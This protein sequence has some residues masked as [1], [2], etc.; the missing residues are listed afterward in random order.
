[1]APLNPTG[2]CACGC[3]ERTKLAVQDRPS[4]GWVKGEPL[5]YLSGHQKTARS[6]PES[7]SWRG[8]RSVTADGYVKVL[9]L[10]DHPLRG[11]ADTY[12]YVP[13]HRLVMAEHLGRPLTRDEIV[14]H[15]NEIPNDNRLENLQLVTRGEH[16]RIHA[17]L[18]THCRYGHRWTDAN[19]Y[20]P[21]SGAPRRCR[22][23]QREHYVARRDGAPCT[24]PD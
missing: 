21:P 15:R 7:H 19:T 23:C 4:A 22:A 8:G 18:S 3:G 10:S 1:M 24:R 2:L 20:M 12:G 5:K 11:M 13:E 16:R 9:L 17:E 14:H 6:G